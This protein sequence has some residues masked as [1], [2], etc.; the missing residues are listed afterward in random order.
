MAWKKKQST[1]WE[2]NGLGLTVGRN[3]KDLWEIHRQ[4]NTGK[5]RVI[6]EDIPTKTKAINIAKKYMRSHPNG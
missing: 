3:N 4:T 6:F 2:N 1:R 5:W